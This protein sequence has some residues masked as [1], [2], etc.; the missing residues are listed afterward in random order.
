[1]GNERSTGSAPDGYSSNGICEACGKLV[2][3][4]AQVLHPRYCQ[5]RVR[6]A[7]PRTTSIP[8]STLSA[9]P[10]YDDAGTCR[11]CAQKVDKGA[12]ALHPRYCM[13]RTHSMPTSV[14]GGPSTGTP[15]VK[16]DHATRQPMAEV[17]PNSP[18]NSLGFTLQSASG[19]AAGGWSNIENIRAEWPRA[20]L[21]AVMDL[22]GYR[23]ALS[24]Y[25]RDDY[26]S[27]MRC[28]TLLAKLLAHTLYGPGILKREELPEVVYKTIYTSLVAPPDGRTFAETARKAVRLALTIMR[29]NRWQPPSLG[30]ATPHFERMMMDKGNYVLLGAAI[31]PPDEPWAGDLRAFFAETPQAT[32][33]ASTDAEAGRPDEKGE[34]LRQAIQKAAAAEDTR[35][36][37]RRQFGA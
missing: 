22:Q 14:E 11:D 20:G 29:E 37:V 6:D 24:L 15:P 2:Q 17:V 23:E 16:A 28:A 13:A 27:M 33:G 10:Q 19:T 18:A 25:E 31:A 8:P 7:H 30:G 32:L 9:D 1:M 4:N 21:D 26:A 34:G 35:F 36:A 5:A 12:R 3:A